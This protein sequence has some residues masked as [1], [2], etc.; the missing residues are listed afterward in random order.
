MRYLFLW[1]FGGIVY[2]FFT[3]KTFE[4]VIGSLTALIVCCFSALLVNKLAIKK[5]AY[6]FFFTITLTSLLGITEPAMFGVT[7]KLKYPFYLMF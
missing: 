6:V 5:I 3:D 2:F 7:L 1:I 4:S